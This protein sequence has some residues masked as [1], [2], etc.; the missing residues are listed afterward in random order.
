M[1]LQMMNEAWFNSLPSMPFSRKVDLDA[2]FVLQDA[3]LKLIKR[4]GKGYP[5]VVVSDNVCYAAPPS[6][7]EIA[8]L[9]ALHLQRHEPP[10]L[11]PTS[12]SK[13]FHAILENCAELERAE[14]AVLK[15]ALKRK[16]QRKQAR[17]CYKQNML[18]QRK[19]GIWN[20]YPIRRALA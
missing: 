6:T 4:R 15:P 18:L 7:W 17:K 14:P 1:D 13:W 16:Q 8:R 5:T 11:P 20:S 2:F 3:D 9:A 12:I 19:N 10:S